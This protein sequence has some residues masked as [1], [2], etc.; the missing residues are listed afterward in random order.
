MVLGNLGDVF[1]KGLLGLFVIVIIVMFA[2]TILTSFNTSI[3]ASNHTTAEATAVVNKFDTTFYNA[4]DYGLMFFLLGIIIVSIIIARTIQ[5]NP[6]YMLFGFIYLILVVI[7]AAVLGNIYD[8]MVL[9]ST[10]LATQDARMTFVP[11][12]MD[13]LVIFAIIYFVIVAIALFTNVG[14]AGGGSE[15]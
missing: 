7:G 9:G 8:D 15:V 11:F 10:D 3:T 14:G 5:S 4:W 12:V 6:V 13:H 2:S 1:Q